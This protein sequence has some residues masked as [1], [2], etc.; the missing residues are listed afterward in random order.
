M[1]IFISILAPFTQ[2]LSELHVSF[3]ALTLSSVIVA[4]FTKKNKNKSKLNVQ[5]R[6][7][8]V[9]LDFKH[10]SICFPF[11]NTDFYNFSIVST[12]YFITVHHSNL[13]YSKSLH[14]IGTMLNAFPLRLISFFALII[15]GEMFNHLRHWQ[16]KETI[17]LIEIVI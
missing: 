4:T 13:W 12:I 3:I 8:L 14:N 2:F 16:S 5:W 7:I 9:S 10:L 17:T 6:G 1:V 11:I 15:L